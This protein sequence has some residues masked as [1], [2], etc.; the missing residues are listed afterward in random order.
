MA[1]RHGERSTAFRNHGG[2]CRRKLSKSTC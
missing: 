2:L 1:L